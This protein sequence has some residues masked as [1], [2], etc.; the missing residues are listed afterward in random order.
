MKNLSILI[1][2]Q[3]F[4]NL[5]FLRKARYSISCNISFF[6]TIIDFEVILYNLLSLV[7]QRKNR[8]FQIYELMEFI[9]VIKKKNLVSAIFKVVVS[10]SKILNNGKKLLIVSFI[11]HFYR[12]YLSR[13]KGYQKLFTS[14][15]LRKIY[16][17]IFVIYMI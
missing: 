1:F 16:I 3:F 7:I 5:V 14:F 13:Y 11:L 12:D 6:P 2:E 8:V 4:F 15:R 10:S 17:Q 9:I